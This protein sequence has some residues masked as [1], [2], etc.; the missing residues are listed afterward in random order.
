VTTLA[1]SGPGSFRQAILDTNAHPGKDTITFRVH[2]TIELAGAL[3]EL[4]G[5]LTITGPGENRLTVR[6][7]TGG[8]YRIFTVSQGANIVVS[9]LTITNGQ[10]V[11][12]DVLGGGVLND[13]G[14]LI[15]SHVVVSNCVAES[16]PARGG[17]ASG[18]GVANNGGTLTIDRSTISDNLVRATG[19]PTG[20]GVDNLAGTLTVRYSTL[21]GNTA[22]II[23]V[24]FG[25]GSGATGG[26][27]E[28]DDTATILYSNIYGNSALEE[29][30]HE[31]NGGGIENTGTMSIRFSSAAHNIGE[32]IDNETLDSLTILDSTISNNQGDIVGGIDNGLGDLKIQ[33]STI[34]DNATV[35]AEL[36][37]STGG[38]SNGFGTVSLLNS[39]VSDNVVRT[40]T[41][42]LAGSQIDNGGND[43]GTFIIRNT[44][45]AGTGAGGVP[46]ISEDLLSQGYNLSTDDSGGLNGPGDLLNTDPRLGPL[47]YNGGATFTRALLPGSPAIDAG[48][49]SDA[50][51]TD[52]RG[53]ARIVNGMIDIGAFEVQNDPGDWV[54][55]NH[56]P[57]GTRFNAA[58]K[59]LNT[60]NVADLK[61]QWKFPTKT[62]V[63]G[64]PAVADGRIY[65][66]DASGTVYALDPSGHLVW[67]TQ[68]A[69]PVTDSQLVTHRQVIFGDLSGCIY[70]LDVA[71]GAELWK[72]RPNPNP[73]AA[74]FSSPTWVGPYVAVGVAS[75]EEVVAANPNYK[76][77]FRGSVVLLDPATGQVI[78][79]TYTIS[80][81]DSAAGAS[82]AGV[83]STPT[84]DPASNTLY[85][86]TGNNYS[87]PTTTESDAFIALDA[88]TGNVK[89]VNQRTKDD[90]WN[91]SFPDS[92]DHPDFDFGDSPQIYYMGGRKVVG[93]G[94]KSG[95]YHVVDAATGAT[96]NQI[97]VE[98]GGELSGLFADS[99]VANDVVF[100]NTSDWPHGFQG[101]KPVSGSLVAIG[102]DGTPDGLK[103]LWHF[104]TPGS[105]NLSGV[106][107]A[108]GVVYFQS[109]FD[110]NLYALDAKT[111]A[112]LAK[113]ATGGQS[114]GPAVSHG[115]VY[116][117][118]GNAFA[119]LAD[120]QHPPPGA[121]MAL[122]LGGP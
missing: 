40:Q 79:Q 88:A 99:A 41:A 104:T 116:L 111:G 63:A 109:T 5:D 18:G 29:G 26:G 22:R 73:T 44:I 23:P 119:L 20:G 11:S 95:F 97:Q 42:D 17:S 93:A 52:Q 61:V 98:H 96:I 57:A 72:I 118:I 70:G 51:A 122:G 91:F 117:G 33:N 108:N 102:S 49:N 68:V 92:K 6:R 82:G 103:E 8:D 1:D 10:V 105:P 9:G 37:A 50:P 64:T 101:G 106:A 14:K 2:G 35:N 19:G 69:G 78:W 71:T 13:G 25:S 58:E 27:L 16:T 100:A 3:P 67:S 39:T 62:V 66:A 113:V 55:Y 32:G 86:T 90:S 31:G 115:H 81:S 89:W 12:T 60:K 56:D 48:D 4:S 46:N 85:V 112:V 59:L 120:L 54:M 24:I 121:I 65:A 47:R 28:N 114:S 110:G 76:P 21:I 74:I 15:L 84:Y 43:A 75:L 107:V 36:A 7:N 77:T 94:Q 53:L 80:D 45:V 87:E 38:I 30:T 83:W 34:S